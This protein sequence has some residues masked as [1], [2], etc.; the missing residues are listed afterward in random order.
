MI[1]TAGHHRFLVSGAGD[2]RFLIDGELIARSPSQAGVDEEESVRLDEGRVPIKVEYRSFEPPSQLEVL[3]APPGYG[4]APIPITRLAPT[5]E[6]MF[7]HIDHQRPKSMAPGT[8]KTSKNG[9]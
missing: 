8:K 5:T 3:W 4:L 1:E 6:H 7:R 9:G 2:V